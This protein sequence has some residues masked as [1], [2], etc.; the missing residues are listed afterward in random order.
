MSLV[1]KVF[2]QWCR[3]NFKQMSI[4]CDKYAIFRGLLLAFVVE[5]QESYLE[6]Q[7]KML[8]SQSG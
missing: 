7:L 6:V 1:F 2:F 4:Y 5:L 8:L 3:V